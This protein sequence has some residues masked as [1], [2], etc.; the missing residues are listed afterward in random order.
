MNE[1]DINALSIEVT[2]RCNLNCPH[3]MLYE[4]GEN[5]TDYNNYITKKIIDDFF[6]KGIRI[7]YNLNFTGGEPLLNV[8]MIIYTLEK[9]MRE[10][11]KVVSIDIATNGTILSEKLI[12]VLNK[13]TEYVRKELF[14]EITIKD[15]NTL[16]EKDKNSI[17]KIAQLRI[18]RLYHDNNYKKAL[19]FY[20]NRANEFIDVYLTDD[21][22]KEE[23]HMVAWGLEDRK[24]IAYSGRAKKL[25][26]EFYCDSPHHKIVYEEWSTNKDIPCVKCPLLLMSNGDIGITCYCSLKD[27][28]KDAIGN[29]NSSKNLLEM[30]TEWNFKTPLNCDEA[31]KLAEAKMYYETKRL[32]DISRVLKKNISFDDLEDMVAKEEVK[33]FYVENYRRLLHDKVPCLTSDEIEWIS[34]FWLDLESQKANN[35]LSEEEIKQTTEEL[36]NHIG[37]LIYEHSFDDVKDVHKEFPYLTHDEC[38]QMEE[39]AKKCQYYEG[40]EIMNYFRIYP[41]VIKANQ[42]IELNEYRSKNV[43]SIF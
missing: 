31:C 1:I 30:I 28:H 35:Q 5:G 22:S 13:F 14:H 39:C 40:K 17:K 8:D 34:Q 16:K 26:A 36:D 37:K 4:D 15:K 24:L 42:L 10:K 32:E 43:E 6:R 20:S 9:I 3:C 27:S 11:I 25:D 2:D 12:N 29:V 7:I 38:I 33:C 19:E 21:E 18:S 41:Y 23:S